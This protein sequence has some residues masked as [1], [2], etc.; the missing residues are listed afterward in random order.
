MKRSRKE[1]SGGEGRE[2]DKGAV[3][4]MFSEEKRVVRR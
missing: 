3:K 1:G 4:P 2:T